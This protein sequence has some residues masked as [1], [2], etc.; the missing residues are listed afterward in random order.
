MNN[1]INEI[2]KANNIVLL[3]HNNPDGD[4][5][6]STIAMYYILKKLDKEVDIVIEKPPVKF[7]Y[8]KGFELIKNTSDKEYDTAI[9]L[10]TAREERVNDPSNIKNKVKRT[11]VLDHHVSNSNYGDVNYVEDSPACCQVVYNIAKEMNIEIDEKIG[12]PLYTGLVTDTGNLSYPK[13]TTS[14]FEMAVELSK[15]VSTSRISKLAND[16]ITREQ[17]ELKKYGMNN[18]EFYKDNQISLLTI[19]EEDIK[20]LGVDKSEVDILANTGR[21]IKDI[22][23]T[24]FIRIYDNEIRVSLRSD[25]IN[26]NEIANI[27]GGGGHFNAAGFT[28]ENTDYNSLK[29]KLIK[30]V[31]KKIDE[32][33]INSK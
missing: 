12:V 13:V 14:T 28:T 25:L 18:I 26:V 20:R 23:I 33:N 4:A 7:S 21:E 29:E 1:I 19:T 17:F 2:Q 31:G 9:I 16:T 15:I 22:K 8:I 24:I 32:W 30:E 5:I 6:G 27:F 11:I 3:C 10:D